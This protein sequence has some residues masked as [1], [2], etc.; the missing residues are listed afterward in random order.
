MKKIS[1]MLV[2]VLAVLI[3]FG[4]FAACG[5]K[6]EPVVADS[7]EAP[8]D[9]PAGDD[10]VAEEPAGDDVITVGVSLF[11]RR[12]EYY[13]DLDSGFV[14]EAEKAGYKLI[15]Q[16]ADADPA[17]QTQQIEDFVTEGVDIIALAATDPDGMVPAIEDAVAAGIPVLTFDGPANTDKVL[18]HVGF[19][20]YEDGE[21]IGLWTKKY[22][23]ENLDGKA[24]IAV[25]DFPQSAIVCV[26]RT[27]GFI[28]AVTQLEGVEIVAQQDG[29][30]ARTESMAAAETILTG[31]PDVDIFFGVNYDTGA[32]AKAA[33]EAAGSKAKVVTISWGVEAF[34]ELANN[35]P[36]MLAMTV[37]QPAVQA[38]DT[39]KAIGEYF[40]GKQLPKDYL[41]HSSV[42]D[43]TNISELDWQSVVARR[44]D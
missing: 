5:A 4:M 22:I 18:T 33:I 25:I 28:D 9:V 34:E 15:V 17:K 6:E 13:K 26:Q 38:A 42:F 39:I 29:K 10:V 3:I 43:S 44:V 20:F 41:S 35:D 21:L 37:T 32:G 2:L 19:D 27:N 1:K 30:A 16:D 7:P 12:D 11:Y 24:K 23:E 36:I 14:Y 40:A 8:A 31:N